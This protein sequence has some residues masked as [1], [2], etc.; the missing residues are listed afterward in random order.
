MNS[1]NK[2]S[3]EKIE[4]L[5]DEKIE[6]YL[7][8]YVVNDVIKEQWDEQYKLVMSLPEPI[9]V[10]YITFM[11]EGE[12][13]NGGYGQYFFN[14]SGIFA[15]DAVDALKIIGASKKAD[16]TKKALLKITQNKLSKAEYIELQ[17]NRE[18]IENVDK[19]VIK[20][21]GDKLSQHE[22]WWS[23]LQE[24][25]EDMDEFDDAFY[26]NSEDLTKLRVKYLRRNM[27]KFSLDKGNLNFLKRFLYSKF[28]I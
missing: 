19:K 14:S 8:D 5:T 10:N 6:Q 13:S 11:L 15:Y 27:N 22:Y 25:S 3:K 28:R 23:I 21:R 1:R 12:I 16:I 7:V 17:K 2:L 4:L 24:Y 26:D 18:L 20:K 9:R